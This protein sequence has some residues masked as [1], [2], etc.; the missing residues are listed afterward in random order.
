[1]RWTRERLRH[2]VRYAQLGTLV[3][4]VGVWIMRLLDY[5]FTEQEAR[6]FLREVQRVRGDRLPVATY[7]AVRRFMQGDYGDWKEGRVA[8]MKRRVAAF[9]LG[10][11]VRGHIGSASAEK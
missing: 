7:W 8:R 11:M 5:R 10:V 4:C 6:A 2:V 1:M 9:W 3:S